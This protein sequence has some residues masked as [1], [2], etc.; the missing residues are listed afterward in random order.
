MTGVD[1]KQKKTL[2]CMLEKLRLNRGWFDYIEAGTARLYVNS[3]KYDDSYPGELTVDARRTLK[4]MTDRVRGKAKS[5]KAG[6]EEWQKEFML[7]YYHNFEKGLA[8]ISRLE[9]TQ[10]YEAKSK[11]LV[12]WRD[13]QEKDRRSIIWCYYEYQPR[14]WW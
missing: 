7:W 9:S 1:Q 2:M 14:P 11:R 5:E 6:F 13:S 3:N 8:E 4:R 10:G 12:R